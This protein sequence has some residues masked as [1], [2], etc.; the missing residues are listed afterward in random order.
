MSRDDLL[1]AGSLIALCLHFTES[2][3]RSER[4]ITKE[5]VKNSIYASA[6]RLIST[7]YFTSCHLL[8]LEGSLMHVVLLPK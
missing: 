1:R 7:R 5:S 6:L 2:M 4:Q 3:G 8:G